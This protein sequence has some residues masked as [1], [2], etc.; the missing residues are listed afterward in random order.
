M[1][2]AQ[3]VVV[4]WADW[5]GLRK[6]DGYERFDGVNYRPKFERAPHGSACIWALEGGAAE[7]E[8]AR[9]YAETLKADHPFVRVLCFP[10]SENDPLG[11]ARSTMETMLEKSGCPA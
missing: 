2:D 10:V 1:T 5:T 3:C 4:A 8:S 7:V 11:I 9:D 6:T